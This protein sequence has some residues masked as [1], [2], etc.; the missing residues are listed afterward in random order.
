MDE[1]INVVVTAAGKGARMKSSLPKVLH[2]IGRRSMLEH[3][4]ASIDGLKQ[5]DKNVLSFQI[6]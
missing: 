5:K 2:Q 1:C 3:V 4:L 6:S